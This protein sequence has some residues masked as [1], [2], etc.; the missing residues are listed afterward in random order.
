MDHYGD[1]AITNYSTGEKCTLTFKPAGWRGK[2]QHEIVGYVSDDSGKRDDIQISGHWNDR[3]VSRMSSADGCSP[4]NTVD[5]NTAPG[6]TTLGR[7]NILWKR[8][9]LPPKSEKMFNFTEFTIRLNEMNPEIQNCL[10]PTDSR[11]RPDQR[12]MEDGHYDLADKEKGRLEEHQRAKRHDRNRRGIEWQPI[13][14]YKT[15]EKD[16]A[17]EHWVYKGGYWEARAKGEWPAEVPRDL[18]TGTLVSN[19][20]QHSLD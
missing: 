12:A 16:T 8:H 20:S 4:A 1:L 14:F 18:Y 11:L 7:N 6:A 10:C 17:A 2:S 15:I 13:W 9:P 5:A 19:G 3:L